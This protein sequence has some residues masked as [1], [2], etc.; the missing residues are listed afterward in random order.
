M[1][2]NKLDASKWYWVEHAIFGCSD[3]CLPKINCV[4]ML[5]IQN[6]NTHT[7]KLVLPVLLFSVT[8]N[9]SSCYQ[10]IN[11]Y[12]RARLFKFVFIF[13]SFRFQL[14]WEFIKLLRVFFSLSLFLCFSW[15]TLM[16]HGSSSFCVYEL[17]LF[18]PYS[19]EFW[20]YKS[21]TNA[22]IA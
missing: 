4:R 9:S 20:L 6:T 21:D 1:Q 17:I 3:E 14:F 8:P 7:A 10:I 22:Q 11:A 2:P 16:M 12:V 13:S 19:T 15:A 18:L 5:D